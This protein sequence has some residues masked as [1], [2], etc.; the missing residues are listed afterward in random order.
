M[1]AVSLCFE[2]LFVILF[3]H[4]YLPLDVISL[5]SPG[6]LYVTLKTPN[7]TVTGNDSSLPFAVSN[8]NVVIRVN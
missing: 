8:N 7:L 5:L 1:S 4:F 3:D 6:A 2:T